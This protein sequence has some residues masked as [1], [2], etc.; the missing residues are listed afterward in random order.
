MEPKIKKG[1]ALITGASTR[2]GAVYADRLANRGYE[3]ILVARDIITLQEVADELRS[4]YKQRVEVIAADLTKKNDLLFVETRLR[5]DAKIS[6]LLYSA[7]IGLDTKLLSSE[8]DAL[9]K[10][11]DLNAI[12]LTR[13]STAA[14]SGFA[15]RKNGIIINNSLVAELNPGMLNDTYSGTNAY[16]INFTQSMHQ[17]LKDSGVQ[18]QAVLLDATSTPCWD[19]AGFSASNLPEQ[20]VMYVEDMVD[21]AL[22]SLDMKELITMPS[23]PEMAGWNK[24][25]EAQ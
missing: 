17:E 22:K 18:I 25:T 1:T 14:A 3:L 24:F 21:A 15:S 11:I 4:T 19:K 6:L 13:L 9:K 23:L 16:V 2:I 12:A 20:M 8:P 7:R 5:Y 10:M